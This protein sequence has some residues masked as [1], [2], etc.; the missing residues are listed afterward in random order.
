[1]RATIDAEGQLLVE[2][3]G[4]MK[5]TVCP[6]KARGFLPCNDQCPLFDETNNGYDDQV[7]RLHCSPAGTTYSI[8]SD[9]R[10]DPDAGED[11]E[12]ETT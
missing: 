1:M 5:Q 8:V 11:E 9:L 7:V 10:V 6:F 2:R 4:T 12:D 3:M